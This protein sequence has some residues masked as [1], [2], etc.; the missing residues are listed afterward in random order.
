MRRR[1]II[2]RRSR[3]CTGCD[4]APFHAIS[5]QEIPPEPINRVANQTDPQSWTVSTEMKYHEAPPNTAKLR[6]V[7]SCL[8]FL[9]LPAFLPKSDSTLSAMPPD[10]TGRK[11]EVPSQRNTHP[12]LAMIGAPPLRFQELAPPPDLATRPPGGAPP[13]PVTGPDVVRPAAPANPVAPAPVTPTPAVAPVPAPPPPEKNPPAQ[14]PSPRKPPPAAIIPDDTPKVRAE[15]FLPFFQFPANG[16][17]PADVTVVA[18]LAPSA[19][20]PPRQ[21]PSS[22]TYRQQ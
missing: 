21:P 13:I 9:L 3:Q 12:Y 4:N 17:A 18:P 8:P 20:L 15:D 11:S 1:R 16:A 2:C 22:A 7:G 5:L 19:P 10:A 6:R 14:P